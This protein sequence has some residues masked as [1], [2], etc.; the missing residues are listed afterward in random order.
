MS[1]IR[2]F[3]ADP[4][5]EVLLEIESVNILDL[6]PSAPITATGYGT[7]LL[8]GEFEDGPFNTPT[9]VF[10]PTDF[11]QVYGGFGYTYAGVIANNPCA[12]SRYA[13]GTMIPEYWNGN[14]ALAVNGKRFSRLV[15]SRVDTSVG[16]VTF[17]RLA[18]VKGNAQA[19][20][21]LTTGQTVVFN[22]G[23]GNVTATFTGTPA[24]YAGG[25]FPGGGGLTGFV[26]GEWVEMSYD[27]G[28]TVRVVFT[29]ADQS[30]VQVCSRLATYLGFAI[31]VPGGGGVTLTSVI[32]GTYGQVVISASNI[33]G[34]LTALGW[35][36]STT[37]GAGNVANI[38]AVTVAEANTICH[39]ASASVSV[40]S[41]ADLH[42]RLYNDAV[43]GT[44]TLRVDSTTSA[45]AFG[46][47]PLD[48]TVSA[49]SGTVG[50]IPAG[51]RVRTAG[52]AEWVTMQS[53][54]VLATTASYTIKIRPA[55]DTNAAIAAIAHAVVVLPYDFGFD[56]WAIDNALPVGD[57][58]TE[59]EIDTLYAA[60]FAVTIDVNTV[61]KEVNTCYCAR[62]SNAVRRAGKQ[63]AIDASS[64]G[65]YG[66]RFIARPPL[67][68]TK[69][70]AKAAVEPGVGAYKH[71]RF[72]YCYP[73]ANVY[74]PPIANRGVVGGAGFTADGYV[75]VGSDGFMAM[76]CSL[77]PPEENPGQ[78]TD[79]LG[80]VVG[81]ES[82]TNCAGFT[83]DDYK[84]FKANGIAALRFDSGVPE[85]QSG[86]TSV[87]P[88]DHPA[89]TRIS[90]RRLADQIQDSMAI[91]AKSYGKKLGTQSR[92]TAFLGDL[93]S[94]LD[95]NYKQR[96]RIE[97]FSIDG[98]KGNT[99][100]S[101]A[102]GIRWAIVKVKSYA[103][104]DS[105]VIQTEI[106]ESV[107]VTVQ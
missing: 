32:G 78:I 100:S 46:F 49:A 16:S 11:S 17:T 88:I 85:F 101:W 42:V 98:K 4:G 96:G 107:N 63:N 93:N 83:L 99:P 73:G 92:W 67:N 2:R 43:P 86:V 75:D 70:V 29:A 61:A 91:R 59:T 23:G 56:T 25:A 37:N 14:G 28:T 105:L 15:V 95:D 33:A 34:T 74:M 35:G 1:Y 39:A 65:C 36:I 24:V 48:T 21:A 53:T 68:T 26:G 45:A 106:G 72:I 89:Q 8:V 20:F 50:A 97:D 38:A 103:S 12:R 87:S 7:V 66:R 79:Y 5:I 60:A 77:L 30:P 41:D 54:E 27:H 6:E 18:A 84:S 31:G 90:R 44:G 52:G 64:Q 102:Q 82:G 57:A 62:Q 69:T 81:I 22:P 104:M 13:D 19:T 58:L 9:E 3:T 80:S 47:S 94:F 40:D 76:L 55:T 10:G 71:E 51:V